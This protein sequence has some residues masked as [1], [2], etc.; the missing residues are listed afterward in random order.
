MLTGAGLLAAYSEDNQRGII[1]AL[2]FEHIHLISADADAAA[3]WYVDK[4]GAE[5]V[6]KSEVRGAPQINVNLGGA[7]LL[8]R[9]QRAGEAPQSTNTMQHFEDYSSHNEWGV[10]HF[11][12]VYDG[13]LRAYAED[14]KA[15]GVTFLVEPYDFLPGAVISYVAAPDNVSIEIVQ[16]QG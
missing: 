9:S 15:K 13:D 5:I 12:L 16:G 2:T 3:Q 8:V 6:R 10:D 4:L 14:L 1:M 11:G 7:T